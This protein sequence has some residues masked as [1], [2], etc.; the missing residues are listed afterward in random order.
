MKKTTKQRTV[1]TETD[2]NTNLGSRSAYFQCKKL[3][4]PVGGGVGKESLLIVKHEKAEPQ[5]ID[6]GHFFIAV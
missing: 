6:L 4:I 3:L 1:N 2:I 5:R